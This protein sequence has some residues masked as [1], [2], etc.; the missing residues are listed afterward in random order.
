MITLSIDTNV[1]AAYIE[2]VQSRVAIFQFPSG[3]AGEL[4]SP[5]SSA[6]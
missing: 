4:R 3:A 5:Y 6:L 1:D 2:L